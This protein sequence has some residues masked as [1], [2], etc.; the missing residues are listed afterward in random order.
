MA[1]LRAQPLHFDGIID[2]DNEDAASELKIHKFKSAM[3]WE[4]S[5][6]TGKE[7]EMNYKLI[8]NSF[9]KLQA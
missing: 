3:S 7:F 9:W 8:N 1:T 4:D 6:Y 2:D 5:L